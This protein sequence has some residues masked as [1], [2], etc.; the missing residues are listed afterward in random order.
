MELPD[1]FALL[2]GPGAMPHQ[3]V[4]II[5]IYVVLVDVRKSPQRYLLPLIKTEICVIMV[6]A[7]IHPLI[8][9]FPHSIVH[10]F[11]VF[12]NNTNLTFLYKITIEVS[13]KIKLPTVR[14]EL[15]TLTITGL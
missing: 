4:Q 13:Q 14:L 1:L 8:H 12:V 15:T 5:L 2:M 3:H 7:T 9:L 6:I 10:T 11:E